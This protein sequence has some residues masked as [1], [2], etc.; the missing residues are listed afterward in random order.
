MSNK[1]FTTVSLE[2]QEIIAGGSASN[3]YDDSDDGIYVEEN[4]FSA[5]LKDTLKQA[6]TTSANHDGA[7]TAHALDISDVDAFANVFKTIDF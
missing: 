6:A 5:F 1:L 7:S 3:G 4:N 2:E